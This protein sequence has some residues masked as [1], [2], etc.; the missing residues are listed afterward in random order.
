MVDGKGSILMS[1]NGAVEALPTVLAETEQGREAAGCW[2]TKGGGRQF[3]RKRSRRNLKKR[4]RRFLISL[5][6][7]SGSVKIKKK[8]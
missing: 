2:A 1:G 8:I 6:K 3:R 5:E 7:K 4:G